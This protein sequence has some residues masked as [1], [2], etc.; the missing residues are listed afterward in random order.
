MAKDPAFLFYPGDWNLGTMHMTLLEKGAYLELLMLQFS[1]G[2]FT[3][4]HAKHMLNGSFDLVWATISEKFKCEEGFYWNERLQLE[5]DKR[6]NFTNSRRTN[7]LKEK[8]PIKTK[9][10]HAKHMLKH[11]E[12]VNEDVI[13]SKDKKENKRENIKMLPAEHEKL[14]SL[15][16]AGFTELCYDHLSSYKI[17]KKYKTNSD[18]LTILRWVVD[19]VNKKHGKETKRTTTDTSRPGTIYAPL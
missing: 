14:I 3:I 8:T 1:R 2:K 11:M 6:A 9:K 4:A 12:D 10:A 16:G 18:Y 17:E 5:K 15:H 13:V 7:A 19:A